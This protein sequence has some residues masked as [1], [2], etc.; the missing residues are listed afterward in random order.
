MKKFVAIATASSVLMTAS[1]PAMAFPV[2]AAAAAPSMQPA[3]AL[4][5]QS[6]PTTGVRDKLLKRAASTPRSK[7]NKFLQFTA[8]DF[9]VLGIASLFALGVGI[10][11]A[12]GGFDNPG[13]S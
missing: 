13:S 7:S 2:V 5:L 10:Y 8:V 9:L 11:A 1:V 6:V 4:A 3:T 12:A